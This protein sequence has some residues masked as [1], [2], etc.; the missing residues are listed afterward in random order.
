ML[1][2]GPLAPLAPMIGL[3]LATPPPAVQDV[4]APNN[5]RYFPTFESLIQAV[6]DGLS[7]FQAHPAA[8]K[9]LM[10]TYLEEQ[11]ACPQA[12]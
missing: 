10:G 5:N 4:L 1:P 12:A 3:E 7:D 8:V 11:A 6:E 9:Q 2:A